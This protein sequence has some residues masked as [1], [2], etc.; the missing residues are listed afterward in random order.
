MLQPITQDTTPIMH[1]FMSEVNAPRP[2]ATTIDIRVE[3]LNVQNNE[4]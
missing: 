1:D 3:N 4:P 2:H